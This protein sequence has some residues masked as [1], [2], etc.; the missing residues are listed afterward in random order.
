MVS[1]RKWDNR[2]GSWLCDARLTAKT[3][4]TLMPILPEEWSAADMDQ[5][6][7]LLKK[8]GQR[9][10]KPRSMD[11]PNCPVLRDCRTGAQAINR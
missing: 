8:L 10:C 9:F 3:Y 6:H 7:L 4:D 1:D 11:R 2:L 5:H